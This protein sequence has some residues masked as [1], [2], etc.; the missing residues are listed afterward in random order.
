MTPEVQQ[1]IWA[2]KFL[3]FTSQLTLLTVELISEPSNLIR[4]CWAKMALRQSNCALSLSPSLS[5]FGLDQEQK[6]VWERACESGTGGVLANPSPLIAVDA[7]MLALRC[8]S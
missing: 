4:R 1:H 6:Q 8:L 3:T 2:M 5:A 7:S